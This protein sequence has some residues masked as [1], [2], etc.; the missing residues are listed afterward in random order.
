MAG[1]DAAL[2]APAYPLDVERI[3]QGGERIRLCD[4]GA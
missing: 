2:T 1:R 4:F 3:E